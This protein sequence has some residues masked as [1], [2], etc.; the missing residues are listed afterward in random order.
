MPSEMPSVGNP[1]PHHCPWRL[2]TG[3]PMVQVQSLMGHADANTLLRSAHVQL[4]AV[5][6]LLAFF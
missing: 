1:S 4:D 5:A 2:I 6:D 3:E